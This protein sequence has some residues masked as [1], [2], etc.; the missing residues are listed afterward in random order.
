M[1]HYPNTPEKNIDKK[2]HWRELLKD[3]SFNNVHTVIFQQGK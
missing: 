1:N 3:L 2:N